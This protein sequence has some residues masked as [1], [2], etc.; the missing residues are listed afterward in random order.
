MKQKMASMRE[1]KREK[2]GVGPELE[3]CKAGHETSNCV[4]LRVR[5][6]GRYALGEGG[7]DM[8]LFA[9][10]PFRMAE[11]KFSELAPC[12]SGCAKVP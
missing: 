3:E 9:G 8:G 4:E 2:L 5:W 12:G 10:G 1:T 7:Q 6:R 11:W